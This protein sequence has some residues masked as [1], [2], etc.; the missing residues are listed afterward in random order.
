MNGHAGKQD[1]GYK[2]YS[3]IMVVL[4]ENAIDSTIDVYGVIITVNIYFIN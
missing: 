1:H 4:C 3:A 2:W